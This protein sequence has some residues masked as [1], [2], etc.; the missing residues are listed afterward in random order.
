MSG[1]SKS[2]TRLTPTQWRLLRAFPE[3]GVH[4]LG[5]LARRDGCR[6]S[7]ATA[8][9]LRDAGLLARGRGTSHGHEYMLRLT[10]AGAKLRTAAQDSEG[11][12]R[13]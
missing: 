12:G 4:F 9:V 5:A 6:Y 1:E 8:E 2:E 7:L 11:V 3:T 13:G 10:R